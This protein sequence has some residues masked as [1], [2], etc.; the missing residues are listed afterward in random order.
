MRKKQGVTHRRIMNEAE[1]KV[2]KQLKTER[3]VE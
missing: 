2:R 1:K 3:V